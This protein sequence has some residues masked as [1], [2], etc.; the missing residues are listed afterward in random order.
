MKQCVICGSD[1][2]P[3][4]V[5][6]AYCDLCATMQWGPGVVAGLLSQI[7]ELKDQLAEC[8]R[9]LRLYERG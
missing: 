8:S 9:Q 7:V 4:P 2:L 6:R 3:S 1:K 5:E